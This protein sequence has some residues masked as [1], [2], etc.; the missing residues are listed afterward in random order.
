L[1]KIVDINIDVKLLKNFPIF[2]LIAWNNVNILRR[3]GNLP[4]VD[5]TAVWRA[6]GCRPYEKTHNPLELI[7]KI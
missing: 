2:I 4:P 7:V 5:F 6:T 3:G 1:G